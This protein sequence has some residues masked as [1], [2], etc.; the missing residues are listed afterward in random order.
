MIAHPRIYLASQS[1]RRRD[2]LKQIG[3]NFEVLLL[4]T[5]PRRKADVDETPHVNEPPHDYVLRICQAKAHAG[6]GV[7]RYRNLP[8]FPVLAADTTV[9]LD[10]KVLGKPADR[11]EAASMLRTLS[12]RQHRV[13][14]AVAIAFD[15]KIEVRLSET[16]VTFV[17]LSE[18]RIRRYVLTSE[19]H[20]KAGA[21]GIQGHAAAFVQ[22]I[23]GS[24]SG[25]VGLPLA[26]T[27]ELLQLSGY[28]AP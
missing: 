9:T 10:G 23:E 26:E 14:S 15:D 28:P 13:L 6:L 20:D 5:D 27:V 7:L 18:E 19:P 25:V 4:R 2:L 3:V 22:R 12:G 21:Y 11:E 8:P 17:T 24:Y 16:T 1:P